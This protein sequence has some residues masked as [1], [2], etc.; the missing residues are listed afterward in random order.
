MS[1]IKGRF[2]SAAAEAGLEWRVM[3]AGGEGVF[4]AWYQVQALKI[5]LRH[6]SAGQLHES[7]SRKPLPERMIRE[8]E[9]STKR[10]LYPKL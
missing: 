9:T 5:S 10:H 1:S 8:K 2:L 6:L 7:Q 4:A 3:A